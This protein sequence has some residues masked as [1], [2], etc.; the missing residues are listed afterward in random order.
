[1][2]WCAFVDES[3]SNRKLDPD[4]YI[5]A[6]SILPPESR[7]AVREAMLRSRLPGERKVHWYHAAEK[8][9]HLLSDVVASLSALHLVVVRSGIPGEPSERRRRKCLE[10]L[11]FE[12]ASAGVS[13]VILE[14]R[15]DRQ[16]KSDRRLID[17]LLARK[18]I[19]PEVRI[20]H[21]LGPAEPL[22]W[23]PDIVAGAV[24]AARCGQPECFD[25]ISDIVSICEIGP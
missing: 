23:L 18:V 15:Q 8:R 25:R 17:T 20:R 12:L 7:A 2:S 22:L 9:R 10:T 21:A 3:E 19:A 16:N 1:M 13:E 14:S 4:V 11:L 6:A 24:V 5:L